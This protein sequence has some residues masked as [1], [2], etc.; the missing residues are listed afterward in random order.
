MCT[1]K[2]GFDPRGYDKTGRDQYGFD[3]SGYGELDTISASTITCVA[4]WLRVFV[5]KRL[6]LLAMHLGCWRE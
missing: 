5:H 6:A 2:N 4:A 3:A 1:D